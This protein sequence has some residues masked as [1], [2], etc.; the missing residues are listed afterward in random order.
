MPLVVV[1]TGWETVQ[2]SRGSGGGVGQDALSGLPAGAAGLRRVQLSLGGGDS[3]QVLVD[4]DLAG[5]DGRVL[6]LAYLCS[7]SSELPWGTGR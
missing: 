1:L 3:G 6:L 4:P 5:P 2:V 7:S